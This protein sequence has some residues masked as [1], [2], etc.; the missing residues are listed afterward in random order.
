VASVTVTVTVPTSLAAVM[1]LQ[2]DENSSRLAQ[3]VGMDTSGAE[4]VT[5]I[6][7]VGV[8]E[9]RGAQWP[10]FFFFFEAPWSRTLRL[11]T[12]L[13]VWVTTTVEVSVAVVY[14][15]SHCVMKSLAVSVMVTQMTSGPSVKVSPGTVTV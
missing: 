13:A 10:L 11:E 4:V 7:V 14:T 12:A 2:A 5:S 9:V 15:V 6:D 3:L 1:H 8:V